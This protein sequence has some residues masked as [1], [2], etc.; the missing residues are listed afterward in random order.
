VKNGKKYHGYIRRNR[1]VSADV[2]Y[3]WAQR[4]SFFRQLCKKTAMERECSCS[5]IRNK[6]LA[7]RKLRKDTAFFTI[8]L[9]IVQKLR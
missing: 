8:P 7:E 3:I 1:I 2:T 6:A 5:A 4:K 9:L